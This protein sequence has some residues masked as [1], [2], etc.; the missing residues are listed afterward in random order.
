M[1]D[2]KLPIGEIT[3]PYFK[4]IIGV[5]PYPGKIQGLEGDVAR[6]KAWGAKYLITFMEDSELDELAITA[7]GGAV[8]SA[9]IIWRHLPIGDMGCPDESFEAP[10]LKLRDDLHDYLTLGG[11][12][13]LHCKG[14]YGRSGSIAARLLIEFGH[15]SDEAIL[16]VRQGRGAAAIETKVQENYLHQ[17][18]D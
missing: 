3:S 1:Q 5:H 8:K 12:V 14:G 15:T 13:A 4:G 11:R 9:G 6:I 10:W 18:A 16:R 7:L 17:L 2:N